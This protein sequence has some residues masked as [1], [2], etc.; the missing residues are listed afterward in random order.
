MLLLF[1]T[2]SLLFGAGQLASEIIRSTTTSGILYVASL[3]ILAIPAFLVISVM[4]ASS[5]IMGKIAGFTNNPN[6]GPLDRAKKASARY[7]ERRQ[8]LRSG[9]QATKA[10]EI[11]NG[12]R[13]GSR[14]GDAHSRRRKAR[15]WVAG[16]GSANRITGEQKDRY[17]KLAAEAGER[18]Y[19]ADRA[20]SDVAYANKL[21]AGDKELGGL[22]QSYALQAKEDEFEKDVKAAQVFEQKAGRTKDELMIRI[23][24]SNLKDHERVAALRRFKE[25]ANAKSTQDLVEDLVQMGADAQAPGATETQKATVVRLQRDLNRTFAGSPLMPKSL[26]GTDRGMLENG[27]L[28]MTRDQRIR[29]DLEGD[30]KGSKV[31]GQYLG[32]MDVDEM[33]EWATD[34][35]A[36]A[37]L[38][39]LSPQAKQRF[40]DAMS[41]AANDKDVGAKLESRQV[42]QMKKL[43]T[44]LGGSIS[45]TNPTFKDK[46][47]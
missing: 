45:V 42:E 25:V 18:N 32:G 14:Y 17:A 2:I 11:L 27:Q 29:R 12:E 28:T 41:E 46:W 4:R 30:A 7:S 38:T 8:N 23:N 19:V 34:P 37:T 5:N 44:I 47:K 39:A 24:D 9:N 26:S 15:A 22:V 16:I 1:P 40:V 3:V 36:I 10:Q 43:A 21:A 20:S 33:N 13:G 35:S 31:N 6:R